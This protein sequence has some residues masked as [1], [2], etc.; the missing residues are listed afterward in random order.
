MIIFLFINFL[1]LF[2]LYEGINWKKIVK[3]IIIGCFGSW[4]KLCQTLKWTDRNWFTFINALI[5]SYVS[6]LSVIDGAINIIIFCFFA[7]LGKIITV[8]LC[9]DWKMSCWLR[10]S[11]SYAAL[12]LQKMKKGKEKRGDLAISMFF[13]VSGKLI[14]L[15]WVNVSLIKH[16]VFFVCVLNYFF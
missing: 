7:I 14:W 12:C 10:N 6:L 8:G 5:T 4:W 3:G 1:F 15:C 13:C 16:A 11:F 9:Y 2:Y